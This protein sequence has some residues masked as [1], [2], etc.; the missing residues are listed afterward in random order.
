MDMSP[1]VQSACIKVAGDWAIQIAMWRT[2]HPSKG[3]SV[4]GRAELQKHFQK[5]YQFLT[6][7]V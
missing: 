4:M 7:T 3:E 2:T 5:S 6:K 1:E